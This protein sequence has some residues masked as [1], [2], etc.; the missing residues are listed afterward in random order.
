VNLF[1]T[2][3][4]FKLVRGIKGMRMVLA[5]LMCSALAEAAFAQA[6]SV[7]PAQLFGSREDA[8]HLSLAPGG[9]RVVYIGP[10]PNGGTTAAIADLA[11]AAVTPFLRATRPGER[12]SWCRFVTDARLV[13][14]YGAIV[15]SPTELIQFSRI[16]AVNADG[17][18]LKQLGQ[19]ESFYDAGLRQFDG[20]IIDWLPG[21][22]GAV[23]MAREFVPEVS[24]TGSKISRN[25]EGLGVTKIDTVS[26]RLSEVEP[27]KRDA[28][29]YLT[30]GRGTVRLIK[31][32]EQR[33]QLLTGRVKYSYRRAGSRE[34]RELNSWTD[35]DDFIPLEVDA[36]SDSLYVLKPLNAVPP[37]QGARPPAG[38]QRGAAR[39]A[40]RHGQAASGEDRRLSQQK[41]RPRPAGPPFLST[42][43]AEPA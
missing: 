20:Q 28:T 24:R 6:P 41:G 42:D 2:L 32:S 15:P 39:A 10:L 7:D 36:S 31:F 4:R 21:G 34:W 29:D 30:D 25:L 13:C 8:S 17:S 3:L 37:L 22:G 40:E 16:V 35:A 18:E 19:S 5:G 26:L 9:K 43:E 12:I 38:G 14:Q 23:L 27:P 1:K 11:T 33:D